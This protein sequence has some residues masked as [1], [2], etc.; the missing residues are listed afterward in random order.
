[1]GTDQSEPRGKVNR[2]V[3]RLLQPPKRKDSEPRGTG[4]KGKDTRSIWEVNVQSLL[5][6]WSSAGEENKY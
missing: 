5:P 2:V 6:D 4:E 3:N 1:M